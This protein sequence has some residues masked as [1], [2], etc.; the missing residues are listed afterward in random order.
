MNQKDTKMARVQTSVPED[1]AAYVGE[2]AERQGIT[3]SA[4]VGGMVRSAVALD[5]YVRRGIVS[6]D[7]TKPVVNG[8]FNGVS[9]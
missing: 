6:A 1:I 8:S 4:L 2:M 9:A 5:M 3:R 7:L